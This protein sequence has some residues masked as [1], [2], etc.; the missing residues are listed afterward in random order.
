MIAHDAVCI[1]LKSFV[2]LTVFKTVHKYIP[3]L[4]SGE[5]IQPLDDGEGDEIECAL[6]ADLVFAAHDNNS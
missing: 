6:I 5:Y 2:L 1:Q 4:F 3:V